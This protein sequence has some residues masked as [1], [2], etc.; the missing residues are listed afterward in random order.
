ML[1]T[2]L[3][4]FLALFS[5]YCLLS[6]AISQL[7]E[8]LSQVLHWKEK[9]A[10]KSLKA[11]LGETQ[12]QQVLARLQVGN[13]MPRKLTAP[14]LTEAALQ[15]KLELPKADLDKYANALM[16]HLSA[17]YEKR[18]RLVSF[19]VAFIV[20]AAS[21]L[22]TFSFTNQLYREPALRASLTGITSTTTNPAQSQWVLNT[23]AQVQFPWGWSTVPQDAGEW[24]HKIV[25]L[26]LTTLMTGLGAPTWYNLIRNL[27]GALPVPT[28]N[29]HIGPP[30]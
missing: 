16:Q 4:V 28:S 9:S 6:A 5:T 24:L 17:E 19:L 12:G 25:G 15:A 3:E 23:L 1:G 7:N 8:T 29:V 27:S 11:I 13:R 26:L 18:M 10:E 30:T 14:A 2:P 20:V 22:D 21:G